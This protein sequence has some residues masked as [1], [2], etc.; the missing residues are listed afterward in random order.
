MFDTC[1]RELGEETGLEVPTTV[2][3]VSKEFVHH[4][5]HETK[6]LRGVYLVGVFH[7]S[8]W[9]SFEFKWENEKEVD[10]VSWMTIDQAKEV[11]SEDRFT[12]L[13]DCK[14]VFDNKISTLSNDEV[15]VSSRKNDSRGRNKYDKL[16]KDKA[17]RGKKVSGLGPNDLK[18][19]KKYGGKSYEENIEAGKMKWL[20]K[21]LS[22]L[23][24]HSDGVVQSNSEGYFN[25]KEILFKVP[26]FVHT[27]VTQIKKV[28]ETNDRKRFKLI[29]ID[30]ELLIRANQGHSDH[31][32]LD[33][34]AMFKALTLE[35]FKSGNLSC[36]HGTTTKAWKI[37][38]EEG[39]S[40]RTRKHIHFAGGLQ[41][42]K[43][44]NSA[45]HIHINVEKA[46]Q[47]GIKFYMSDNDV[48]LT[49]G[50][51][52][53]KGEFFILPEFFDKVVLHK[54]KGTLDPPF[55]R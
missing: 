28:V 12:L 14:K 23:L 45:I 32:Q 20:S 19:E 51:L 2:K 24:R 34:D 52:N 50:L 35:D 5:N 11:L 18:F 25:V 1:L 43:H 46:M 22:W 47:A 38:F 40:P 30:G 54:G 10:Q 27:T 36:I 44:S 7:D 26:Q 41:E 42:S 31:I 21:S 13:T 53:D 3:L 9:E 29:E 17:K 6:T 55:V 4:L 39:L 49:K 37:I 8:D 48:I 15:V 16:K 33:D